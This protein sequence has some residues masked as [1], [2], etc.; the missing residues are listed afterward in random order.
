MNTILTDEDRRQI[1][2]KAALADSPVDARI[3]ET[4]AAVLAKLREQEPRFFYDEEDGQL[5]D[6]EETRPDEA[7]PLYAAPLP[8]VVPPGYKLVPVEILDRFPEINPS[9]YD[10]DDVCELNAWGAEVV[11]ATTPQPSPAAH[12]PEGF[13]QKV[14][15]AGRAEHPVAKATLI[16]EALQL[17]AAAPEAPAPVE[18]PPGYKLVPVRLLEKASASI[19]SFV[20][21]HGWSQEDMDT[22]DSIDAI[23]ASPEA[24]ATAAVQ[25]LEITDAMVSAYLTANAAYWQRTDQLPTT[26]NRWRTGTPEEATREGL[27]AA[28]A[29]A[30]QKP[31]PQPL[32]ETVDWE[33]IARLLD[34]ALQ[35]LVVFVDERWSDNECRPLENAKHAM[36]LVKDEW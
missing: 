35:E 9:N 4:E 15:A 23:L 17:I 21:D 18:V 24:P 36:G 10:H 25:V 27:A 16:D 20:S 29:A 33:H 1:H 32:T 11:L 22:M 13:V 19:G 7:Y 6:P 2:R 8:A 30:P 31:A 26:P 14:Q 3:D 12:V 28:L 5:F 34:A